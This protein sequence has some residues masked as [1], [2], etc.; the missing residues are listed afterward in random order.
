[1]LPTHLH[2]PSLPTRRPSD[3]SFLVIAAMGF[4]IDRMLASE[5]LEANDVLLLG[6]MSLLRNRL[7]RTGS[8]ESLL[9]SPREERLGRAGARERSEEHTSELQSLTNLVCPL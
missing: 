9:A 7:T 5:L 2:L 4:A 6:N 8:T 1:T 3:L